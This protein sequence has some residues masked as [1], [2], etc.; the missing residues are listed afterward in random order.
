[1]AKLTAG[2]LME[3]TACHLSALAGGIN[4]GTQGSAAVLLAY[5]RHIGCEFR[6]TDEE[7]AKSRKTRIFTPAG[8]RVNPGRGE[9]LFDSIFPV[10]G[11][12]LVPVS[13]KG[14]D[15]RDLT[16]KIDLAR[17]WVESGTP[18]WVYMLDGEAQTFD[19]SEGTIEW[20]EGMTMRRIDA[21]PVIR[22]FLATWDIDPKG[23]VCRV[24]ATKAKSGKLYPRLNVNWKKVPASYWLDAE[25]IPFDPTA[26]LPTPW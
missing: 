15:S 23:T 17:A 4:C 10:G 6:P 18:M 22:D 12:F 1:M 8:E 26:P 11:S 21:T 25:P 14:G 3:I 16:T 2:K 20:A 19:G 9:M 7:A 13:L 5:A 24:R